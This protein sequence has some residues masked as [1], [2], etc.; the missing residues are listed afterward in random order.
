MASAKNAVKQ[1]VGE[2]APAVKTSKKIQTVVVTVTPT[3]SNDFDE[4]FAFANGVKIPFDVKVKIP[5]SVYE[6]LRR[7]K[8]PYRS[9][10]T[11]DI[12]EVMDRF[13]VSRAEAMKIIENSETQGM[14]YA[15]RWR[16]KYNIVVH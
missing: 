4:T 16:Q 15:I 9:K 8:I 7:Q 6:A 13:Q 11:F 14:G 1:A 10:K 3:D 5:V 2:K 12:R